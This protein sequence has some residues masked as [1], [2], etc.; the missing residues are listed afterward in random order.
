MLTELPI[1]QV[2]IDECGMCTEPE[3][4]VPLVSHKSVQS[5]VLIGDHRQL[6]PVVKNEVCKLLKT[7]RSLFERYEER[8]LFLDTQY[9]M[10]LDICTFP[11]KE[12]YDNRLLTSPQLNLR[13]SLFFSRMFH[14]IVF[15]EVN[16][17]EQSLMVTTEEGNVSSKANLQEA[18]EAVRLA[19][20]LV[21]QSVE[22]SD[23]AILTAYNAQV[24][25][26]NKRLQ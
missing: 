24:S 2:I 21:S 26:I 1:T 11:S 16:G 23:I 4:L 14:R 9:R 17:Q 25:E 19:A 7:D 12:F 22:Q 6:R 8:A 13:K 20:L 3:S 18:K 10:H 15:G 5:I